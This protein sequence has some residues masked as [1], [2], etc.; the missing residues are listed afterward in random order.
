M[1]GKLSDGTQ[2]YLS[3]SVKAES[4]GLKTGFRII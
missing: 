4:E 2:I 3:L 1:P